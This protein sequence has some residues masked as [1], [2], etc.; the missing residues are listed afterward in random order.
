[1]FIIRATSHLTAEGI[2]RGP[3]GALGAIDAIRP[4]THRPRYN[5]DPPFPHRLEGNLNLETMSSTPVIQLVIVPHRPIHEEAELDN[6]LNKAFA[7]L[8]KY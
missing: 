2:P 4:N 8:L 3:E 7:L 1:M 5:W 6:D